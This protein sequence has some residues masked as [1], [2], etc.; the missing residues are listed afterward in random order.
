MNYIV[1]KLAPKVVGKLQ[2]AC[3]S[4]NDWKAEHEPDHKPWLEDHEE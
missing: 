4:Y 2:N 1:T 3:K